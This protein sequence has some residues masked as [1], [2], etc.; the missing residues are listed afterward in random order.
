MTIR[1]V[2]TN[3]I[4][5]DW[6]ALDGFYRVVFGCTPVGPER[7]MGGEW[8][9]RTTALPGAWLRGQHLR[10]PGCGEDG[11]TLEIFEYTQMP[12]HPQVAPNTPGFSHI[13]FHVDDV[14][15]VAREM[16]VHGGSPVG[17]LTVREVAGVGTLTV[18]YMA[19][20]EGNIIEL[21]N[22]QTGGDAKA[23]A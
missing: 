6:R 22:W 1:Y 18:R 14:A 15:A 12:A 7:D 13:A 9:E 23:P 5:R 19:D 16:L 21:Q 11:P 4:A 10:M 20:P 8:L 3:L 17:E 2:H